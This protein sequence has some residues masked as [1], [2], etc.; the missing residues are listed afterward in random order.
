MP[1][2]TGFLSVSLRDSSSNIVASGLTVGQSI[3]A[4]HVQG[5]DFFIDHPTWNYDSA[6]DKVY[7]VDQST[8]QAVEL[9][10]VGNHFRWSVGAND[11][12]GFSTPPGSSVDKTVYAMVSRDTGT[13]RTSLT[14]KAFS[15]T[16]NRRRTFQ[17]T[18][19]SGCLLWATA[20]SLTEPVGSSVQTW[21]DASA[22]DADLSQSTSGSRPVRR[23]TG[24]GRPYLEFDG[25]D[26]AMATLVSAFAAPCT[27]AVVAR[28]RSAD[29]TVRGIA[30]VGGTNGPRLAFDSSHLKGASGS[31]VADTALPSLGTWFVGVVTKAAGG[32]VTVQ[33]NLNSPVTATSSAAVTAGTVQVGDTAA[34]AV[35]AVDVAEVAVWGSVLSAADIE[36]LVNGFGRAYGVL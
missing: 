23:N 29:A 12:G 25:T 15:L 17:P 24:E 4:S 20:Y 7:L 9:S 21:D 32:N 27:L 18:Q 33:L 36:T 16:L 14:S 34:D 8:L 26:D 30:Q 6:T 13:A 31:D 22:Q 19:L 10:R 35:A 1:V 11:L 2:D 3:D 5:I 28:V